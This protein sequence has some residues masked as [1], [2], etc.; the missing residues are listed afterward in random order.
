MR[1]TRRL[2]LILIGLIL[3]GAGYTYYIQKTTQARNAPNKPAA[4]P[5]SVI[6]PR[7]IGSTSKSTMAYPSMKSTQRAIG[8]IRA[9]AASSSTVSPSDVQ[10][11]RQ[12]VRRGQKRESR[13][14]SGEGL[15]VSEGDVEITMGVGTDP[16]EAAKQEGRLMVIKTSAVRY[17]SKTGKAWTEKPASFRFDKGEGQVHRRLVRSESKEFHM[18]KDVN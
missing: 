2:I 7:T 10:Q 11:G 12:N 9:V 18:R 15:L 4:L 14:R 5:D 8:W 6:S 16:A 1:R 17:E 13:I 3:G